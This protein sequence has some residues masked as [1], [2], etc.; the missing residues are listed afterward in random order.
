MAVA[1]A[2]ALGSCAYAGGT[3]AGGGAWPASVVNGLPR[4]DLYQPLAVGDSWKYTCRDIKGG[5]ENNGKPFTIYDKVLGT[6]KVGTQQVSE[7]SLQVP[8]VPS[9]PLKVDTQ[10][11]LLNNDPHGNLWMHGYLVH[12]VVRAVK[13]AEIVAYVTPKKGA[14]FGYTGPN[15][16]QVSRIFFGIVPTNPTPLGIF[17]VADYEESSNTHD[18]GYAKG[19]GIAEEDHGPNFEVDCLIEAVTLH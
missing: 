1:G 10:I 15:G 14:K 8:Q 6:T 4:G 9:R 13:A 19:T 16:K 18:Y 3:P 11:M 17:T 2:L 7:F 5:G 12:G